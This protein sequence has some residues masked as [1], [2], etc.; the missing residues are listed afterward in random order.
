[1]VQIP[2]I[3]PGTMRGA[4]DHDTPVSIGSR[5]GVNTSLQQTDALRQ[6]LPGPQHGRGDL[7]LHLAPFYLSRVVVG[8]ISGLL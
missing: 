1:V 4:F 3:V 6:A 8:A 7:P 5:V 2:S